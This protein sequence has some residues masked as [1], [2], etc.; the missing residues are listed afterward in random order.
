MDTNTIPA[1]YWMIVIGVLSGMLALILY[2]VAMLVKESTNTLKEVQGTIQ[3]SREIIRGARKIVDDTSE[4]VSGLK[5]SL[6]NIK[7]TIDEFNEVLIVPIRS[8]S[9]FIKGFIK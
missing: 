3:D 4:V 6:G 7:N 1:L 9:S 5:G 2:Y 8:I